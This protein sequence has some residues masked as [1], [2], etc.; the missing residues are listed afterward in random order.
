MAREFAIQWFKRA[1][2]V[3][4]SDGMQGRK[5]KVRFGTG[6][7]LDMVGIK[8]GWRMRDGWMGKWDGKER[9][10]MGNIGWEMGPE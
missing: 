10:S 8:R 5:V 7:T 4:R 9:I 6:F 3:G 1:A 2:T